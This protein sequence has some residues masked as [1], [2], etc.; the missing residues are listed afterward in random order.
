LS[1]VL[2]PVSARIT[3]NPRLVARGLKSSL[4]FFNPQAQPPESIIPAKARRA[5]PANRTKRMEKKEFC[6]TFCFS[7]PIITEIPWKG[8][9]VFSSELPVPKEAISAC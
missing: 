9:L 7:L 8:K 5:F 4:C 2:V 6:I 3:K 1:P